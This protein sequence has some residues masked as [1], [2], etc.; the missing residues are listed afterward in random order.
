MGLFN[1]FASKSLGIDIGVSSIKIVELSRFLKKLKLQNYAYLEAADPYHKPFRAF[2][3]Q[4]LIL[5]VDKIVEVLQKSFTV[6]GIEPKTAVF[7]VADF[8]TFFTTFDLPAMS[9]EEL[10][11]AVRFEAGKYIPLPLNKVNLD[12]GVIQG[13]REGSV[14]R[15]VLVVAIPN[16]VVAQ[17]KQVAQKLGLTN[18]LLEPEAFS[19]HRLFIQNNKLTCLV[20]IGA[21]S[22]AVTIGYPKTVL[23]SHSLNV[24]SRQIT[25]ELMTYLKVDELT[26]EKIKIT[27]GLT[28]APETREILLPLIKNL[29]DGIQET[30]QSLHFQ[31]KV[32]KIV[33]TG[34]GSK[35][36]GLLSYLQEYLNLPVEK[37]DPFAQIS[38]PSLLQQRVQEM[39]PI[40]SVATGAALRE[41][42]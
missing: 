21:E 36:Q 37:G 42:S 18:F 5:S 32:A 10:D 4:T 33:L 27:Q 2:Q 25:Q 1:S 29:G 7:S 23:V 28:G 31:Q 34:G 16:S 30:I 11:T 38:Y 19:L 35:M 41:I 15:K 3:Q 13:S 8:L 20:D 14:P 22:T 9:P 17:Y 26:A 12:W 40:L 39:G 24:S 6:S